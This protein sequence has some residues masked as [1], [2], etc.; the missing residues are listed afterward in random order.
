MTAKQLTGLFLFLTLAA[1]RSSIPATPAPVQTAAATTVP[2]LHP[3]STPTS[4]PPT[5]VPSTPTITPLP[6]TPTVT[7]APTDTPVGS[8]WQV[9]ATMPTR[10]SE[11]PAVAFNG[12]IY[13]P[14]GYGNGFSEAA[15]FAFEVYDPAADTF[16]DDARQGEAWQ[17]L[18][19]LPY[20]LNHHMMAVHGDYLYLFGDKQIPTLRYDPAADSWAELAPM[21]ESRWAGAAAVL[22]DY[23]YI[24]GG[25]GGTGALLRYDPA[26]DT[27]A[28]LAPLRQPRE[29]L[30]AVA[31][32][33]NIY[34]LGGRWDTGLSSVEIYD[35]ASDSWR[36]GPSMKERR[37]G[38]GATVWKGRIVV[39]GGELLSPPSISQTVELFDPATNQWTFAPFTL[40]KPLHGFPL[41][42]I[43]EALYVL[44]GSGQAGDIANRGEVWVR[45][46]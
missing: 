35:P 18:A 26:T 36:V 24:V 38:F 22:D 8:D 15:G 23:I 5:Q 13:V 25:A 31:F 28:T 34:A 27:W 16:Q 33:G 11:M 2:T 37:S 46:P 10:R 43:D 45:R 41:V 9:L 40:P 39:A 44:G 4:P 1:C 6:A 42:A 17:S 3:T 7:A 20:S 32:E 12:L 14:G 29:H 19:P 21:P 30:Q